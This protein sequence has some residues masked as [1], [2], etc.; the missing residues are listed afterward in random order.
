MG[1]LLIPVLFL[2]LKI[3]HNDGIR[4]FKVPVSFYCVCNRQYQ[5]GRNNQNGISC[6][7]KNQ[8]YSVK[9]ISHIA[10]YKY[11]QFYDYRYAPGY[12]FNTLTETFGLYCF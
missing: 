2:R 10:V 9:Y 12:C 11:V 4:Q 7:E 1:S 8:N 3:L 5:E 6:N